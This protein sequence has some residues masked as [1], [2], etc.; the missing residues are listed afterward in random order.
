[1]LFLQKEANSFALLAT[2]TSQI[3]CAYNTFKILYHVLSQRTDTRYIK[4]ERRFSAME[5]SSFARIGKGS[6]TKAIGLQKNYIEIY[7]QGTAILNECKSKCHDCIIHQRK[8]ELRAAG[9]EQAA[10]QIHCFCHTCSSSVWE[11]SYTIQKRYINE[12]NRYGYQPTLKS[13]AIKLFLLYHFLQPDGRG[14]IKDV[15]IKEL[16]C[17]IGC[18]N[19]TVNACNAVLQDY[20]Y[21]Y[22]G[23]SG[24]YDHYINVLLPEYKDYHKT[25]AEGGRGYITM[26]SDLFSDLCGIENLNTLRLNLRGILE[27]DNASSCDIQNTHAAPVT[28][29]YKKLRGFLPSYCKRNVI[30]KA[31]GE[32]DAIFDLTFDEQSVTFTIKDKYAQ[33]NLREKMLEDTK[34][35]L[36]DHVDHLNTILEEAGDVRH[37]KEKERVDA[38]LSMLDIIPSHKYPPLC[39]TLA[40]YEDLASLSLQYSL[41]TVH[42][43][44]S[45]IYNKYILLNRPVETFGALARTIIRRQHSFSAAS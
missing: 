39:L 15:S 14:F 44:I 43:A 41:H 31:L 36:I 23:H 2:F 42:M 27:V 29:Q 4:K 25:A 12:K 18:T 10:D 6:L 1:M 3:N 20:G 11:T 8:E 19:A 7:S 40:D 33:K 21:C 24:L 34:E 17:R 5:L 26:S 22:F 16:A 30:Q 9:L 28:S 13:N 32:N 37:P 45:T 35:R 38:M